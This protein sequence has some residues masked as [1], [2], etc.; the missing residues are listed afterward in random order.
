MRDGL[1][2][3]LGEPLNS[4]AAVGKGWK[5]SVARRVFIS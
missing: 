5:L 3:P 1:R 4:L 2:N